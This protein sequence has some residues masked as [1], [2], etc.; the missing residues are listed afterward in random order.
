MRS[1]NIFSRNKG[2]TLIEVLVS[3]AILGLI[4]SLGLFMSMDVYRGFSNRSEVDTIVSLLQRARA[5]AMANSYQ[6]TWGVCYVAP[7]YI[8]FRGS[9][10]VVGASTNE[11]T[12]SNPGAAIAGLTS[13]SPVVFSQLAGTTSD[14]VVSI[15]E[16]GKISTI[17]INY[18]GTI[19][20]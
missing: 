11:E 20:W 15:T 2:F 18:E 19:I 3:I 1:R 17:S 9:T 4:L 10:C 14:A 13:A 7:T 6:T 16:N 5:S 8:I 12:P